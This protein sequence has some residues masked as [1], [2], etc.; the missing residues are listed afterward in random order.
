MTAC[1]HFTAEN[2]FVEIYLAIPDLEVKSTIRIGTYPCLVANRRTLASE[3]R[4]GD[5]VT[6]VALQ[7]LWEWGILQGNPPPRPNLRK[8]YIRPDSLANHTYASMRPE[9]QMAER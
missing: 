1:P 4:Q 8:V 7:A 6:R 9:S 2:G 3:V 5:K